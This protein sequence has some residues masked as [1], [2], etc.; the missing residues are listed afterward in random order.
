MNEIQ[1]AMVLMQDDAR[2]ANHLYQVYVTE[3]YE[4]SKY[5]LNKKLIFYLIS[6]FEYFAKQ[7]RTDR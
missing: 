5:F 7:K 2:W 4:K 3:C 6:H 1:Y